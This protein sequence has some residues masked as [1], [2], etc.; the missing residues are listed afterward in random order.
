MGQITVGNY[1]VT[2]CNFFVITIHYVNVVMT[3][4]VKSMDQLVPYLLID[5]FRSIKIGS[6]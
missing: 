3:P 5:C 6:G 4:T 1:T 2:T